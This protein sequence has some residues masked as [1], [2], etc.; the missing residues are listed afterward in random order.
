[1]GRGVALSTCPLLELL[2]YSPFAG[3]EAAGSVGS[4][5]TI[6]YIVVYL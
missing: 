1:M 4:V 2:D 6:V 3:E 5:P